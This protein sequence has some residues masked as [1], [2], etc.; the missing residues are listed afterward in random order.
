MLVSSK[1]ESNSQGGG[2]ISVVDDSEVGQ[3]SVNRWLLKAWHQSHIVKVKVN[4]LNTC[5]STGAQVS[6]AASSLMFLRALH[7]TKGSERASK[8]LHDHPTSAPAPY[9]IHARALMALQQYVVYLLHH[10]KSTVLLH[11]SK[12]ALAGLVS[13]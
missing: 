12:A 11:V 6:K 13:H 9:V 5:Q 7:L 3:F 4:Y 10:G 1:C 2:E 8:C